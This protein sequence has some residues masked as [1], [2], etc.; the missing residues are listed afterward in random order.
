LFAL[1]RRAYC[2]AEEL[3]RYQNRK[4]RDVVNYAYNNVLFYHKR[5][6]KLGIVPDDIK[7]TYDL[8]KLPVLRR[9]D[10]QGNSEELVSSEC[11]I[12]RLK[13]VIT[14]GSTGQP[15]AIYLRK[16]EDEFR[17]AK[18]LRANITLGQKAR[19][20]WAVITGP[21]HFGEVSRLQSFLNIYAPSPVSVFSDAGSQ[22]SAL[23]KLKPDILDGYSSSLFL[24]AKE[25]AETRTKAITPRFVIGGSELIDD[26]QRQ[27]IEKSFNA[28]FY[29]QYACSEL[30]R[31]AWQCKERTGYHIDADS[32]IMQFVDETGEEVSP[33]ES[34]EIVCTSL[35]NYAMPLIRYA[36]G[37]V[38]RASDEHQCP[39]GRTF[40]LMKLI[41][42]RKDSFVVFPD[43]RVI[44]PHVL[45]LIMESFRFHASLDHYRIVQKSVGLIEFRLKMKA[46]CAE[47]ETVKEELVKHFRKSLSA[48]SE[49]VAFN[50]DFVKNIALDKSGKLTTVVSELNKNYYQ[51]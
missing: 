11:E 35:F 51:S 1:R 21:Q 44:S 14:S 42:G 31:L 30:E 33:G 3:V 12:G 29:D 41:E 36:T 43:G 8:N 40:P 25:I 50:V 16:K 45:C 22:I 5:L 13:R 7:T 37:D 34:G 23:E 47:T 48:T 9:Q 26:S 17:K 38:G 24:L 15:L 39:C 19:D 18:H 10:I 46:D 28:P 32:V 49:E 6:K 2:S 4:L 20:R 27:F